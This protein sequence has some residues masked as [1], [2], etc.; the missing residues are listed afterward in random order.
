MITT[1]RARIITEFSELGFL[2]DSN[3]CRESRRDYNRDGGV[4]RLWLAVASTALKR[5]GKKGRLNQKTGHQLFMPLGLDL[6]AI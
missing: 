6:L 4:E 1:T 3:E 2:I 5:K